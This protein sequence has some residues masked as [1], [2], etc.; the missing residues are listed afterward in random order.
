MLTHT[1][2]K[3]FIPHLMSKCGKPVRPAPNKRFCRPCE[4]K[5]SY[6]HSD[7]D[8]KFCSKDTGPGLI[9]LTTLNISSNPIMD[10]GLAR[11]TVLLRHVTILDV[12]ERKN[13]TN[14]GVAVLSC[15]VPK[16][17]NLRIN[18]CTTLTNAVMRNQFS[19]PFLQ[20]VRL[21]GVVKITTKGW[22]LAARSIRV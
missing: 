3:A 10:F 8:D 21:E 7:N 14:A 4:I 11:M 16:L 17:R 1:H 9:D 15:F 12:S 22:W 6:V 18:R 5:Y 13:I 20:V 19:M 2:A